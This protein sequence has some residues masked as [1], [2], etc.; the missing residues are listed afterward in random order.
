MKN[1]RKGD[2]LFLES[3]QSY[4]MCE[5]VCLSVCVFNLHARNKRVVFTWN[6]LTLRKAYLG[7]S[8][9]IPQDIRLAQDIRPAQDTHTPP[10]K[11]TAEN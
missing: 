10:P 1:I 2:D 7:C 9:F 4:Q 5:R 3:L 11:H 6:E 8:N